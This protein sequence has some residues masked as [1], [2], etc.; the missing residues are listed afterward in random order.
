MYPWRI[1]VAIPQPKMYLFVHCFSCFIQIQ[2]QLEKCSRNTRA[3]IS[4]ESKLTEGKKEN[5]EG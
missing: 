5:D 2:L 4:K 1:F 3:L